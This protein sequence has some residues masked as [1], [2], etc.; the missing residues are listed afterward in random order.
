[1]MRRALAIT[2]LGL[3]SSCG[4]Q[5]TE[6]VRASFSPIV[7]CETTTGQIPATP[8]ING[9]G[10]E[11]VIAGAAGAAGTDP[12]GNFRLDGIVIDGET[13]A[14]VGGA[15]NNMT[16][17][18]GSNYS[19]SISYSPKQAGSHTAVI[20]VAFSAPEIQVLQLQLDGIAA[21]GEVTQCV[22]FSEGSE[23]SFDGEMTLTVENLVAATS[24]LGAALSSDQGVSE[25][26][27][28]PLSLNLDLSAKTAELLEITTAE[29]FILPLPG[30]D[31]PV[32]GGCL[33]SDTVLTSTGDATGT[34]DPSVGGI[35][36]EGVVVNL[37]TDFNTTIAV[38][39]TTDE[40][41]L[42]ALTAPINTSAI[43][44]FGEEHYDSVNKKIFG[45]RMN[46]DPATPTE[47]P[48]APVGTTVIESS[49]LD[50][51]GCDLTKPSAMKN[52]VLAI[53]MEGK[54]SVKTASP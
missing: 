28:V 27:P 32:L 17:P 43:Q 37:D 16:I 38:T 3:F 49:T 13:T 33:Q 29:N 22:S 50:P 6:I 19:F 53:L 31:V 7:V 35:T 39:L 48:I 24:K 8:L 42:D 52:A 47:T 40:V 30:P 44:A 46:P 26:V 20:D 4:A 11:M 15:L 25:F 34:Y 18:P 9:T 45:T 12:S 14:S 5:R 1:M 41:S 54:L 2:L 36:L 51:G 23:V 10:K 21:Q